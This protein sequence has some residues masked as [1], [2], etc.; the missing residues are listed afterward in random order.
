[1]AGMAIRGWSGVGVDWG[2]KELLFHALENTSSYPNVLIY[3]FD[4]SILQKKY[5]IP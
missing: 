1:V 5:E 2:A 4:I 3:E